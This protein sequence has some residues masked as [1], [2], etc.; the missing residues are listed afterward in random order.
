[1]R[2]DSFFDRVFLE[3]EFRG[4]RGVRAEVRCATD[5]VSVEND[6]MFIII[7]HLF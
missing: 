7:W 4:T 3:I 5:K 1:M 6:Q 2:N